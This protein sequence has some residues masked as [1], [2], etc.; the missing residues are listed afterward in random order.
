MNNDEQLLSGMSL[1]DILFRCG[2]LQL[3]FEQA[4]QLAA[5]QSP[6]NKQQLLADLQTP[7]TDAYQSYHAGVAEGALK[8]NADLESNV[9]N[10]KAKDA[11]NHLSAERRRQTINQKLE[12][13]FGI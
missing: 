6:V 1:H 11:Y 13:L 8:L 7:G 4:V 3:P 2:E 9:G 5:A 10:P 12:E